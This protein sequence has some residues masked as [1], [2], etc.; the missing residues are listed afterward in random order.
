MFWIILKILSFQGI[1][2]FNSEHFLFVYCKA[3]S[4]M[5]GD[6]LNFIENQILLKANFF[7]LII[8]KPFLGSHEV[9]QEF[10]PK[11]YTWQESLFSSAEYS[12]VS[13]II[14]KDIPDNRVCFLLLNMFSSAEYSSVSQIITKDIPD[15]RVCFLLLNI[16]LWAK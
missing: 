2:Y 15:N 9:P 3:K 8:H 12:S 13:Q 4:K 1:F 5:F 6:F 10:G 14:T 16:V 11:R 7:I